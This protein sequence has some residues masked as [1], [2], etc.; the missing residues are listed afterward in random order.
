MDQVASSKT[1][2]AAEDCIVRA[3]QFFSTGRWRA[4]TQSNR[5]ATFVGRPPIPVGLI[6]VMILGFMACIIPGVIAYVM[7]FRK[8]VQLQNI[9]VTATPSTGGGSEVTVKHSKHASKLVKEFLATL[10][11]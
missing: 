10:P 11:A 6:L 4:Q 1:S 7:L 2:L 9:V 3:V 5:M 8:M